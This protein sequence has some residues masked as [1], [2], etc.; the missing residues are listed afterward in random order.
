[1]LTQHPELSFRSFARAPCCHPNFF[2]IQQLQ[3]ISSAMISR[4][5][6]VF[7]CCLRCS[8]LARNEG[9]WV[10]LLPRRQY[11][12][13]PAPS[14][15]RAQ[16]QAR[17]GGR[18]PP[19]QASQPLASANNYQGSAVVVPPISFLRAARK[20][21]LLRSAARDTQQFLQAYTALGAKPLASRVRQL[22]VSEMEFDISRVICMPFAL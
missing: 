20:L 13:R 9:Q 19:P 6:S 12:S 22:C 8:R 16:A 14:T 7:S 21:R 3:S 18:P 10:V 5:S 1:M 2:M 17:R 15:R 4:A 11:A